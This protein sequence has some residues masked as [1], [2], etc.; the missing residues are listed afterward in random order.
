MASLDDLLTAAK[1]IVTAINGVNVTVRAS[2]GTLTSPTLITDTVISTSPGRLVNF[3]VT[4]T[5]SGNGSLHNASTVATATADNLLVI[6]PQTLG[7]VPVGQAFSVGLVY[8]S[9]T[10][11]SANVTYYLG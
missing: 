1:N 4:I 10:G 2:I 9:G 5:G 3:A 11:Q 8:K 7:V 6:V